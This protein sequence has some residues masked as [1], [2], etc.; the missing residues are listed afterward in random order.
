MTLYTQSGRIDLRD[1]SLSRL[2]HILGF[3]PLNC[4]RTSDVG[5]FRTRVMAVL[6]PSCAFSLVMKLMVMVV[7][8]LSDTRSTLLEYDS[9]V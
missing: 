9:H 1:S 8:L 7:F 6:S 5:I 2:L 3:E 4:F